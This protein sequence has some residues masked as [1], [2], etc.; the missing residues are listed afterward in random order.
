MYFRNLVPQIVDEVHLT[1][2]Y[3]DIEI[4]V[5]REKAVR[6]SLAESAA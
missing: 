6:E 1:R 4:V 3:G 5:P 2:V